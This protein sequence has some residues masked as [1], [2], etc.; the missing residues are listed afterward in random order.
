M[1]RRKDIKHFRDLEVYEKAFKAA[2]RIYDPNCAK[3]LDASC[4]DLVN[5]RF[6]R[7]YETFLIS[8]PS[9]L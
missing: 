6:A 1:E 3:K 7:I 4:D 5:N 2:M 8:L 9:P